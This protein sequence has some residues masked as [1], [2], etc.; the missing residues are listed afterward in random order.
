MVK[1][2]YYCWTSMRLEGWLIL[3]Y[4]SIL[5]NLRFY[6]TCVHYKD[7][8]FLVGHLDQNAGKLKHCSMSQKVIKLCVLYWWRGRRA[9]SV[10]TH[11]I[12]LWWNLV[13]DNKHLLSP[14]LL[15]VGD[16]GEAVRVVSVTAD[17]RVPPGHT[18]RRSVILYSNKE[19]ENQTWYN[20]ITTCFSPF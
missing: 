14:V 7:F 11:V 16:D 5:N 15:P 19:E 13:K 12:S 18:C 10:L 1:H 3:L 2:C 17:I 4:T 9:L 8:C 6:Y 20:I